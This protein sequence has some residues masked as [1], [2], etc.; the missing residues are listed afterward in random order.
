MARDPS[1]SFG[2]SNVLIPFFFLLIIIC[3]LLTSH[4]FKPFVTSNNLLS[5]QILY[6]PDAITSYICN[7]NCTDKDIDSDE[8]LFQKAASVTVAATDYCRIKD[9]VNCDNKVAFMFMTKGKMPLVPLWER[10]FKGYNGKYSIYVHVA[11]ELHEEP[12]ESSVFH[13]R[14]IP[15]KVHN[16]VLISEVI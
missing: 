8:A 2:T 11:L 1:K 5:N 14:T 10:F 12:H 7:E 16:P 4:L 6:F 3:A 9:M 15:S 13:G